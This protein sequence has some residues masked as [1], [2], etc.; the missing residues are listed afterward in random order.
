MNL[1]DVLTL[2]GFAIFAIAL[3]LFCAGLIHYIAERAK[4]LK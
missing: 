4:K 2:I 1:N 3:P